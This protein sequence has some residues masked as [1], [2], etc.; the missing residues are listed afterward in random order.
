MGAGVVVSVGVLAVPSP[1]AGVFISEA[2]AFVS[3]LLSEPTDV[4]TLPDVPEK[5]RS[6]G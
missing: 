4:V 5:F 6:A 3:V 2:V 1:A